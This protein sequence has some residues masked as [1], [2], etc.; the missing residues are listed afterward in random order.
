VSI[1]ATTQDSEANLLSLG[2]QDQPGQQNEA[3]SQKK[4]KRKRKKGGE[5][6]KRQEGE[7]EEN[8]FGGFLAK[9]ILLNSFKI[10]SVC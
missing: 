8:K 9:L 6:E 7:K 3:P 2:V 10:L 1:I 4:K 5:K